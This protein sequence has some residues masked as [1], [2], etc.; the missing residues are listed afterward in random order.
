MSRVFTG[1][2]AVIKYDAFPLVWVS[3]ITINHENRLEEIPQLDHLEV[4]EYA[5]NGHRVS[6]TINNF[7]VNGETAKDLGLDPVEINTILTL[8]EAIVEIF[9]DTEEG[10][11]I[12]SI[13]G[14]KF[15]GGSGTLNA[16]GVWTG[17][18]NFKGRRGRGI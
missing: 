3:S 4:A 6:F 11:V 1:A 10:A 5:E 18:W 8:P 16:R 9:D 15:E 17:I 2:K 14:V 13:T 7:K 12:Y